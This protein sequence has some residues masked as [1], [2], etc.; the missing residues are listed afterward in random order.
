MIYDATPLDL[1]EDGATLRI[2]W[3]GG[4][5]PHDYTVRWDGENYTL[6]AVTKNYAGDEVDVGMVHTRGDVKTLHQVE[7][8]PP[9]EWT[10]LYAIFSKESLEAMKGI[11]GKLAAQA[12]GTTSEDSRAAAVLLE[13][14]L[15]RA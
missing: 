4:N 10:R 15:G 12:G 13:D 11:R 6:W 8:V 7:V 2:T 3:S 5:G 14:W 9:A 1:V